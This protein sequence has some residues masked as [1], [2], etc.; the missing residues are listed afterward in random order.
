MLQ[1]TRKWDQRFLY[2]KAICFKLLHESVSR[3]RCVYVSGCVFFLSVGSVLN[4]GLEGWT[5]SRRNSC[6]IAF[7]VSY[8][9]LKRWHNEQKVGLVSPLFLRRLVS[10]SA[11]GTVLY[12]SPAVRRWQLEDVGEVVPVYHLQNRFRRH[13]MPVTSNTFS[14]F[15]ELPFLV[16]KGFISYL[17]FNFVHPYFSTACWNVHQPLPFPASFVR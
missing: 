4:E 1:Y 13:A 14:T 2:V 15:A 12:S 8:Y 16:V 5:V 10:F 3:S 17:T 7:H 9:T 6:K 11:S